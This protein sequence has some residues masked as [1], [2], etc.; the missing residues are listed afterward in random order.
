MS[1]QF[2]RLKKILFLGLVPSLLFLANVGVAQSN[3]PVIIAANNPVPFQLN[4][5]QDILGEGLGAITMGGDVITIGSG[6]SDLKNE[7]RVPL[8]PKQ[9]YQLSEGPWGNLEYY[10][11]YLQVPRHYAELLSMPSDVTTWHFNGEDPENAIRA[12]AYHGI[13]TLNGKNWY[14]LG[15]WH[16]VPNSGDIAFMPDEELLLSLSKGQREGLH[17]LLAENPNNN[18][19]VNPV[20]VESGDPVTWYREAG[21]KEET[22]QQIAALCYRNQKAVVFSDSSF[23]L[24]KLATLDERRKYLRALTRT[25]TLMLRLNVEESHDFDS[26]VDYWTNGHKRK[27]ILPILESIAETPGVERIDVAHLLPPTPRKHLFTYPGLSDYLI[28]GDVDC[29]WTSLNFFRSNPNE[30]LP[31]NIASEIFAQDYEKVVGALQFGDVIL[32]LDPE[33]QEL[34]HS[35]VF[36]AGDIVYT[37][38]GFGRTNPWVFMR[39]GDMVTR[40]FEETWTSHAIRL[41]EVSD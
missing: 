13:L 31:N 26:V 24:S 11:T 6:L 4:Y 18:D 23:V 29:H 16:G 33:T 39:Y 28:H 2:T 22:V 37:K 38:N 17:K 30:L 8:R 15:Q 21:L 27:A 1:P 14:E 5:E 25:R 9:V 36:I 19:S 7:D 34:K 20:V 3:S 40:Y 41:K 35:S 12:M 10:V 32:M